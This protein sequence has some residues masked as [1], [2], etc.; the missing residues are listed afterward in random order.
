MNR[1]LLLVLGFAAAAV[2]ML[3]RL[4]ARCAGALLPVAADAREHGRSSRLMRQLYAWLR[5]PEAVR[6]LQAH[7]AEG[8]RAELRWLFAQQGGMRSGL[9]MVVTGLGVVFMV[10]VVLALSLATVVALALL[11]ATR[12]VLNWRG[13]GQT[14]QGE[15]T[16]ALLRLR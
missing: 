1:L 2:A 4:T 11:F 14:S 16:Q 6:W 8:S 7:E 10:A 5:R 3:W 9:A 13:Q 15:P 12:R